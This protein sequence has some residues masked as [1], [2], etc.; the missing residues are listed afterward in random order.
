VG[1][2]NALTS[3]VVQLVF[4]W[5]LMNF[6]A[7]ITFALYGAFAVISLFLVVRY[8]PETKGRTLEEI[9]LSLASR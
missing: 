3:F 6:G 2:V 8:F 5:E 4:P 1:V 7:A 9:S